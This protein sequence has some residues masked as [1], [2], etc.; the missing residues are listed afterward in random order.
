MK[1]SIDL[2]YA[3][4]QPARPVPKGTPRVVDRIAQKAA[5][6]LQERIC[7]KAVKARDQGKC[8]VCG[9]PATELHH[10]QKRSQGGKWT[11]ANIVS[12]CQTCHRFEHAALL[13]ISGSPNL[14]K[15]LAI[16]A[17]GEAGRWMLTGPKWKGR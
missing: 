13:R 14:V 4:Q 10:L 1:L 7:R 15:P 8:R 9:R 5:L 16:E 11:E 12:L 3:D 6:A 2:P 17:T